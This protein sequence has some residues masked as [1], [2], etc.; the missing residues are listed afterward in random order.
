[1]MTRFLIV[2]LTL[3]ASGQAI[4]DFTIED[5]QGRNFLNDNESNVLYG[6]NIVM[7]TQDYAY[8]YTG[9]KLNCTS[10]HRKGGTVP[11]GLPLNVSGQY[12][13]WL[14][15]DGRSHGVGLKIRECFLYGMNGFM[16]PENAPE[17]LAIEAYMAFLSEGQRVAIEPKGRG[18]PLLDDSLTADPVAGETVYQARCISCH[19]LEGQGGDEEAQ[20]APPV[21]GKH[22]YNAGSAM[23]AIPTSAGFI[24][25]KLQ[26]QPQAVTPQ[27]ALDVAAFL[28]AQARGSDPSNG[29]VSEAPL[30]DYDF[31]IADLKKE[32]AT[33]VGQKK[34]IL[35]G[36]NIIQD[37][38]KH[39]SIYVGNDLACR[40]CH[41]QAGT[42][43]DGI[44][45][46]VSG[47]YP[48]WRAKNSKNNG[49][50]LRIRECF[51]FS[52]NGFMPP[53]NAPQVLSVA[54]YIHYLSVGEKLG[55]E[56]QGRGAPTLDS[57]GYDPDPAAGQSVYKT[58]CATCHGADGN[59]RKVNGIR[60]SPPVW[61][62]N[63]YNTGAGMHK[64]TTTA[65]YIW[66]NMPYGNGR[67]L[68]VQDALDVAAYLNIQVR[69][70]DPRQ[71]KL[72]K[73]L[74]PIFN[75]LGL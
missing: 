13:R 7:K 60:I 45:L 36:Y 24:W 14:G 71:N 20:K 37:T 8:T 63:S 48:K 11:G 44:P 33:L 5:L 50:R 43:E 54:A 74:E 29:V 17:V 4:A 26:G 55:A 2:C 52:M 62:T 38:Q 19:G 72:L 61:T 69:G 57:T 68:S 23:Q 46:N 47:M 65:G 39:A 35:D 30:T 15:E 1:M 27:Q 3:M 75:W 73:L 21:W 9:N 40:N 59:G 56:P 34:S 18:V 64:I 25:S 32:A 58:K 28:H 12:P 22:S 67:S 16:P 49:L 6:Y 41:L 66:A 53:E 42:V 51:K 10:C 70:T 31:T